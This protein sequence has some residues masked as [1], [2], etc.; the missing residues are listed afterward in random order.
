MD[1]V[2]GQ[3]VQLSNSNFKYFLR[4]IFGWYVSLKRVFL[5]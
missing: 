2:A 1:D 5:F 4:M 3:S